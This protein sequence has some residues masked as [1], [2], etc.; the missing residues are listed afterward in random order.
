MS[1]VQYT[2]IGSIGRNM[3]P[4]VI[5]PAA[6]ADYLCGGNYYFSVSVSVVGPLMHC[7]GFIVL[8]T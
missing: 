1:A 5:I 6:Q 2:Y 3:L 7:S 4:C 8:D